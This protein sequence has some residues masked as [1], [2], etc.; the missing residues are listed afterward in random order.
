MTSRIRNLFREFWLNTH[1]WA[2]LKD[3]EI[4]QGFCQVLVGFPR[5][6]LGKMAVPMALVCTKPV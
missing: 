5:L 2:F 3:Q 1:P 6:V 4:H